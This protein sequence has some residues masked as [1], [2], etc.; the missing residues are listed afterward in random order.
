MRAGA[1]FQS[2]AMKPYFETGCASPLCVPCGYDKK[3]V[4]DAWKHAAPGTAYPCN[5]PMIGEKVVLRGDTEPSTVVGCATPVGPSLLQWGRTSK[6]RECEGALMVRTP[7]GVETPVTRSVVRERRRQRTKPGRATCSCT[8][9]PY[10]HREGSTPLCERVGGGLEELAALSRDAYEGGERDEARF[11]AAASKAAKRGVKVE[12]IDDAAAVLG[13]LQA[14]QVEEFNAA[15]ARMM[16][17][18]SD[19][20][21]RV[22]AA[23]KSA[24]EAG[25]NFPTK[26]K[27][28]KAATRLAA[29]RKASRV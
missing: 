3:R 6:R 10:P 14:R 28:R 20:K 7:L 13:G 11:I 2:K 5:D 22:A 24:R 27:P 1:D 18:R 8:G 25:W 21:K 15:T 23:K 17:P 19:Y 29:A 16:A 9:V 4:P 26:T 12:T